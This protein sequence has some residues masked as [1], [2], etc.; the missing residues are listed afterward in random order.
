MRLRSF[1]S[2]HQVFVCEQ[3]YS[4]LLLNLQQP[5]VAFIIPDHLSSGFLDLN[6]SP[7][8]LFLLTYLAF[9]CSDIAFALQIIGQRHV[10]P[11]N[12]SLVFLLEPAS[13]SIMAY[14]ILSKIMTIIQILGASLILL[15]I[16]LSTEGFK[17]LS[18]LLKKGVYINLTDTD[19]I[20]SNVTFT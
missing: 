5:M 9:M 14:L 8:S 7:T 2:H 11:D 16:M 1:S 17:Y 10:T 3:K 6:L 12:A 18:G 13:A 4:N 15:D 20:L 19:P